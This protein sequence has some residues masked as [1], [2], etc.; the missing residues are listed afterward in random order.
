MSCVLGWVPLPGLEPGGT[1]WN[2]LCVIGSVGNGLGWE[3]G[4]AAVDSC[5]Q[6]SARAQCRS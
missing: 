5:L 6:V 3:A 1:Q 4:Q 2:L